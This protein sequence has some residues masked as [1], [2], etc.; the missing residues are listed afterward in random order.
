MA[1]DWGEGTLTTS[2]YPFV[3]KRWKRG[4]PLQEAKEV[5]RGTREEVG[6][7]PFSLEGAGGTQF[8]GISDAQTFFTAKYLALTPSGVAP[9]TLPPKATPRGLFHNE[10]LFTIE[11]EW[12]IGG[13][14]WATGSLLS[15]PQS[16]VTSQVPTLRLVL[17]PGPRDSIEEVA[18]TRAGVLVAR[19]SNVRGQLLRYTFDGRQWA[20]SRLPLSDTGAV[21]IA[22]R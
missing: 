5:F 19:Y 18:V 7:S 11:Q 21:G 12:E 3:V 22:T 2:G 6:V 9:V 15:M 8:L 10:F 17:A 16:E 13:H 4:T 1:T 14:K 20:S